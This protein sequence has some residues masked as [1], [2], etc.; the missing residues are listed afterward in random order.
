MPSVPYKNGQQVK[1]YLTIYLQIDSIV[2]NFKELLCLVNDIMHLIFYIQGKVLL[3][4]TV[5][6]S[7]FLLSHCS[8]T[9]LCC[10]SGVEYRLPVLAYL[11]ETLWSSVSPFLKPWARV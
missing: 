11:A 9:F 6:S 8:F 2:L 3:K 5:H 7:P 10:T 1:F 4:L